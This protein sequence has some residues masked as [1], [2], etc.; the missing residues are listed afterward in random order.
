MELER[1][2]RE[3]RSRLRPVDSATDDEDGAS[4]AERAPIRARLVRRLEHL[5]EVV[6]AEDVGA[7]VDDV[8][9]D[10]VVWREVRDPAATPDDGPAERAR[11]VPGTERAL[12]RRGGWRAGLVG[13]GIA[14]VVL[15][16]LLVTFS[17]ADDTDVA[18]RFT[19]PLVPTGEIDG[20]DGE[21]GIAVE[22]TGTVIEIDAELPRQEPGAAYSAVVT[23]VDGGDV[24]V[25]TF[26]AGGTVRLTT[27][28]PPESMVELTI[29]TIRLDGEPTDGPVVLKARVD[30]G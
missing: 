8:L 4:A 12:S 1:L 29:R 27:A 14:V 18:E 28:V 21:I 20:V 9:A 10:P 30:D 22:Q 26:V 23:T 15:F 24:V 2:P 13:A 3:Q 7:A 17:A 19:T 16:A 25:G 11:S 6:P 5:A